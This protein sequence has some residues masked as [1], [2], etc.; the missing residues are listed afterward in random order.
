[1][2]GEKKNRTKQ[3]YITLVK[4]KTCNVIVTYSKVMDSR[5]H[6]DIFHGTE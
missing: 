3:K 5:W 6:L 1:M 4:I 2:V